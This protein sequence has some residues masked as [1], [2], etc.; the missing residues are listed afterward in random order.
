MKKSNY[1]FLLNGDNN[2]N[3]N[4]H[5]P[6]GI[7][8]DKYHAIM[9]GANKIVNKTFIIPPRIRKYIGRF[10]SPVALNIAAQ[11]LYSINRGIP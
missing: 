3:T 10:V 1:L 5:T 2:K 4:K 6:T 9:A 8:I 11:K 7:K